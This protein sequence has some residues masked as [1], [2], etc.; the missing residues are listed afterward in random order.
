MF[1][2]APEKELFNVPNEELDEDADFFEGVL[3]ATD[4]FRV[5]G[6]PAEEAAASTG[7]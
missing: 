4:G 6:F 7:R 1:R 3:G 2:D 5:V